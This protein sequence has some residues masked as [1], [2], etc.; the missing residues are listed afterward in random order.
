MPVHTIEQKEMN[1][2]V[3]GKLD[4]TGEFSD[5][6]VGYRFGGTGNPLDHQSKRHILAVQKPEFSADGKETK[7]LVVA[8]A[9]LDKGGKD[10]FCKQLALASKQGIH[11]AHVIYKFLGNEGD[12]WRR[13]VRD[14]QRKR[15]RQ[16]GEAAGYRKRSTKHLPDAVR[17]RLRKLTWLEKE[18]AYA[19]GGNTL[20]LYQPDS[21][22]LDEKLRRFWI[23]PR[24][25]MDMGSH[26]E[27][28]NWKDPY[29]SE[30]YTDFTLTPTK[31]L[32]SARLKRRIDHYMG[33]SR[34]SRMVGN[35]EVLA[36]DFLRLPSIGA[37]HPE[38]RHLLAELRQAMRRGSHDIADIADPLS[39]MLEPE[40]DFPVLSEAFNNL[41]QAHEIL[42]GKRMTVVKAGD[43]MVWTAT[44]VPVQSGTDES[45][46][47]TVTG[48]TNDEN[49]SDIEW[50]CNCKGNWIWNHCYHADNVAEA[51]GIIE[52]SS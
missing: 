40:T 31:R 35:A 17:N 1:D 37:E 32:D 43:G 5:V 9:D 11:T 23:R 20:M 6:K 4:A 10:M 39:A 13:N 22:R 7:Y 47:Y 29:R 50:E 34:F 44:E 26:I 12:F 48:K 25:R 42:E 45:V 51:V 21:A 49:E 15:G 41:M 8:N 3:A 36:S 27:M 2:Y 38:Q 28:A 14:D 30:N 16:Y 33:N 46:T 52:N 24:T 19:L 18:M